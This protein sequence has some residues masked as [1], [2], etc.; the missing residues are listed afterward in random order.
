MNALISSFLKAEKCL[1]VCFSFRF[2]IRPPEI[3]ELQ[4]FFNRVVSLD[5]LRDRRS[6]QRS[7]E[8]KGTIQHL[9]Q[10][11]PQPCLSSLGC[12]EPGT[13]LATAQPGLWLWGHLATSGLRNQIHLLLL[14]QP[15]SPS[16]LP[17]KLLIWP[18]SKQLLTAA[19]CNP[20]K[21]HM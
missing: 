5:I 19:S 17:N 21:Q 8:C 16:A 7:R 18:C 14:I 11:S 4:F 6:L 2:T 1:V 20:G 10:C 12:P 9:F 15:G 3:T 13:D